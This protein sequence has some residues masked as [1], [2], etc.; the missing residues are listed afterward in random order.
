MPRNRAFDDRSG[1]GVRRG[2][3]RR[4][5]RDRIMEPCI[6]PYP[7]FA[8]PENLPMVRLPFARRLRS[9]VLLLTVGALGPA[10][11]GEIPRPT[12]AP[13][14]LP[15]AESARRFQLPDG[16]RIELMASEPA[17]REPSGV[18]WDERGRLFV[19]E[20]HGYNLEGQFD[21]EELN[22]T[23]QL[24][25]AVRRIQADERAKRA[26]EAG[27]YGT[28][29]LLH[30]TDGDGRF[31]RADVWADRLPTCHGIC[32]ARGGIIAACHAEILYLA[33][34][35]G[36][37]RAEVRETLF[38]G[39]ARGP[40][41]RSISCPQW[42]SDGW[43]YA[44]RGAGGGTIRGPHLAQPVELPGT[45]FRFRPDG[46]AI[47]PVIGMSHTMGF[48][49]TDAGDRFVISTRTPG[50]FV[51]PLPWRYL[52]R[53]PHVAT[54]PLE[55]TA[56][57]EQRV[58]PTSRPHPWRSRRAEDPGFAKFYTDHY[59]KEE[60]A[61]NGF[62]TSAC[63][64][65]V[66]QDDALP[67]L[68][69]QLLACEPAQNLVHRAIVERDGARLKLRR[70]AEEAQRE[71]LASSDPWFHPINLVH[72]PDGSVWIVD[73]YREIIEDYS[74][75]P[76]YLQQQYGV[77]NGQNHGRLWRLSHRDLPPALPGDMGRLTDEQ[78]A[79]ELASP[80]F[81][82]RETAQRLL[83]QRQARRAAP[84]LGELARTDRRPAVVLGALA[85]LEALGALEPAH[86]AAA[87]DHAEPV[88]RRQGLRWAEPWLDREPDLRRRAIALAGDAEAMVRLQAALSLGESRAAESLSALVQLARAHGAEP[89]MDTALLSAVPE[90]GGKLLAELLSGGGAPGQGDRLL[91]PLC[92]AIA[93][94][95]DGTELSAAVEAVSGVADARR[96][97][98]CLRGFAQRA[99]GKAAPELSDAARRALRR[100]AERGDDQVLPSAAA[101]VA[102]WKL[103][104]A[105]ERAAR[106]AAA[107]RGM[108]DIARPLPERLAAVA[109]LAAEDDPA[110]TA[111]LLAGLERSTPQVRTAMVEALL[112]RR[113]RLPQVVAALESK[114]LPPTALSAAQR[115]ALL[116]NLD[117]QWRRRAGA[118]FDALRPVDEATLA[119]YA[120][121]LKQPR[122]AARGEKLFRERCAVCHAAQGLG[123]AVG[124]D[125]S[126]EFQRAEETIVEDILAPSAALSAGY[127]TTVVA[128]DDGQLLTGILEA[129]SASSVTLR[130]QE[131]KRQVVL[132]SQ[133]ES[134]RGSGVSLMPDDL[135]KVLSPQDVAD[136]IAWL[137][138]PGAR[139][140]L[141]D[142]NPPL[143]TALS[144]GDGTAMFVDADHHSGLLSLKVTPLQRHAPRIAGW[145]FAIRQRPGPG[146]FRYL[147]LAWKEVGAEGVMIEL[148]ADGKWPPA[149]KP[150]RRYYSGRNT[151]GWSAVEVSAAAPREWTVVTRDLWR[152]FGE[153]T[154]TGIAPTAMGGA[155]LFDRI[156]LLQAADADP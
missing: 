145:K 45:D 97:A 95:R 34:R 135:A 38:T 48:A 73:F 13:P 154:L 19:C 23:G 51:A 130:Q 146:E 101:L 75:I 54:P 102:L 89:W 113:E 41:E 35:D 117:P 72:A 69:G 103:E 91:A 46:S 94:R 50:I 136:V 120:A 139:L 15:P 100:L 85:T 21:I 126:A 119:R 78:L 138:T 36:D 55:E 155:A 152:D 32:P 68:A 52:A 11:R 125:L 2:G 30:D 81:W 121:A 87:L 47:E 66:Y 64:P 58:Y 44:G 153:F 71:F 92:A 144:E 79:D 116:A 17:I 131:G 151:S 18:C 43:I 3:S 93:A 96:L 106:L 49:M 14:P 132:R 22:K 142:D 7:G 74:A 9:A 127:A 39:F 112:A 114:Q 1:R 60:S 80:R 107:E 122:D 109:Q 63:S 62:F 134:L 56:T 24:D 105:A 128:T 84:Q 53:N 37:G 110:V 40:L 65:L 70:P 16:F 12:D 6:P 99:G 77:V 29:K 129:E 123:T 156:E 133:I 33:D 147:R 150:L 10:A 137:R 76:R 20:L 141:L 26:A 27:T 82:R 4:P 31:D 67:G 5:P 88:V 143:A 42:S 98:A 124:P 61:P 140:V 8:A 104:S 28:V 25:R 90:S 57:D 111:L 149:E 108:T 148:A 118:I 83:R 115:S 59:G 86:V